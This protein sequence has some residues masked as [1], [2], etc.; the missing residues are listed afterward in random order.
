VRHISIALH[1]RRKKVR[2]LDLPP[3][4]SA[5]MRSAECRQPLQMDGRH[6][7]K[8]EDMQ[9]DE[10][11]QWATLLISCADSEGRDATYAD[12]K[13]FKRRRV[14][15]Y[16]SE[17][18]GTSAHLVI[19]LNEE[20]DKP[21]FHPAL[22]EEAE[23]LYRGRVEQFLNQLTSTYLPKELQVIPDTSKK[24]RKSSEPKDEEARLRLDIYNDKPV[25]ELASLINLK[26]IEV[27][28]S[29]EVDPEYHFIQEHVMRF[30]VKGPSILDGA[31][32]LIAGA[33]KR[34]SETFPKGRRMLLRIE[35]PDGSPTTIRVDSAQDDA[36]AERFQRVD[37]LDDF[38]K[39]LE[40]APEKIRTEL[41]EKMIEQL[42][43]R[44]VA[45]K[46]SEID[47]PQAVSGHAQSN[48]ARKSA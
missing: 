43:G 38:K 31:R 44:I 48:F 10:K 14:P 39:P 45:A 13:T 2:L 1:V 30:K 32:N 41:K 29:D 33:W 5:L 35:R 20:I 37:T 17:G 22:L 19:S 27:H 28:G 46:A 21:R 15:K 24:R 12:L 26:E 47:E 3:L 7:L 23:G 18:V 25:G 6:V 34:T 8:L 16:D 40:A 42:R 4:L 11:R 36:L 9:I